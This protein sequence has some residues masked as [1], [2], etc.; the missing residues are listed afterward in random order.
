MPT[1]TLV[2]ALALLVLVAHSH[3]PACAATLAVSPTHP[4]TADS[5]RVNVNNGFNARC[6]TFG[7]ASCTGDMAD[8]LLMV[9]VVDYCKGAPVCACNDVSI[10]YQKSCNFGLLQAGVYTAA[11]TELHINGYDPLH[12]FT[13]TLTF[14]VSGA[15]PT[16]RHSW[17]ALKSVYR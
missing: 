12:T 17:G 2:V 11:F 15:T 3:A 13:Q 10:S 1:R 8:T 6:W 9:V 14:T 16:L 4:T 5:V 7:D